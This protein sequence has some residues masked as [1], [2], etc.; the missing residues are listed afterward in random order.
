MSLTKD[1]EWK[2]TPL[3]EVIEQEVWEYDM[4]QDDGEFHDKMQELLC[5]FVESIEECSNFDADT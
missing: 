5:K 4:W 1:W 3:I 2:V